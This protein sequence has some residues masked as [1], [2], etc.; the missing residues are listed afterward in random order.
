[1]MSSVYKVT[2]IK[3][4][5]L[6]CVAIVDIKKGSLILDEN[7]QICPD[8]KEE[9][10]S[11]GWIKSLMKSFYEMSKADQDEYM[12]L[13]NKF[14]NFQN[15]QNSEDF[16]NCKE[17]VDRP[18]ASGGARGA[19]APPLFDRSTKPI[20]TRVGTL[21]PPSTVCPTGFPYLAMALVDRPVA[22]GGA[23][24]ARAP[25]LVDRST[26]PISTRVGTLSP[27]STVC[28][29]G[30]SD[31]ATALDLIK[32]LECLKLEIGEIEHDPRK[33]KEIL[34]IC[35]IYLSNSF[36]A[37]SDGVGNGVRIKTSRFN[38]SCKPNAVSMPMVNDLHQVRAISN[39]KSGQEINLNYIDDPF[40]GFRNRKYRQN[41][42]F[43]G[44]F[45][46]CSCDLCEND[47]DVVNASQTFIQDAEKFTIDR[48]LALK[49][50][51]PHGPLYYSLENC[52]K[53]V[54]CYK[55]LYNVGKSQNIQPYSLYLIVHR[56]FLAA[57]FGNQM[58]KADD[59]K[60]DAMNFAKAAEKFG[61]IL[62]NEIVTQG[63]PN[64]YK[65][66]YK[67]LV[68]KEGY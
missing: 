35:N 18:V 8:I 39:I 62:G 15:Y 25:P 60:I 31:L 28:P 53:E 51:F 13:H 65:E 68:D 52:R 14:N 49:A 45:F 63:N 20:S 41:S 47:V 36:K 26:K 16:Q 61:K 5:G 56:G 10:L 11:S 59:L 6:G 57:A 3:G 12:T 66:I 30:F 48:Q 43:N 38:H 1:M 34:K 40:C 2:E 64:V 9:L 58:Y 32:S 7:P 33:T 4:K 67:N 46:H 42:L 37:T 29:S 23:R 24:G 50:G 17:I 19:H 21:S 55:K 54:I 22:S 27:P 44:W